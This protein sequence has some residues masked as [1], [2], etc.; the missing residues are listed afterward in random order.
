M[1]HSKHLFTA[2]LNLH[3]STKAPKNCR[4][5]MLIALILFSCV[6]VFATTLSIGTSATQTKTPINFYYTDTYQGCQM[7]YTEDELSDFRKGAQITA[8][9]FYYENTSTSDKVPSV[10]FSVKMG[11]TTSSY[12]S[13]NTNLLSTSSLTEVANRAIGGWDTKS[14]GWVTI[15]LKTPFVYT[16]GNILIDIRNTS[17]GEYLNNVYFASTTCDN[18]KTLSWTSASSATTTSISTGSRTQ[19][20]PNIQFTYTLYSELTGW[21]GISYIHCP[22]AGQFL[23]LYK[24]AGCP[25]VVKVDG[26]I[27]GK[28]FEDLCKCSYSD[29]E[30]YDTYL[31]GIRYLD[32]S[33]ATIEEYT[34]SSNSSFNTEK[35]KLSFDFDQSWITLTWHIQ[36]LVLPD[37]CEYF[38]TEYYY[39]EGD[40]S[41]TKR[42]INNVYSNN[43]TPFAMTYNNEDGILYVPSGTKRAWEQQLA[44]GNNNDDYY[45]NSLNNGI[46][47]DTPIKTLS[48]YFSLTSTEIANVDILYVNCDIDAADFKV[49]NKMPQ[50]NKLYINGNIYAYNGSDGPLSEYTAYAANEIPMCAFKGN[51]S[52]HTVELKNCNKIGDYAFQNATNL[53]RYKAYINSSDHTNIIGDYAFDGCVKLCSVTSSCYEDPDLGFT[54]IGDFAFRNSQLKSIELSS[55]CAYTDVSGDSYDDRINYNYKP[56]THIGK[57]PFLG[58]YSTYGIKSYYY[59][60]T[61]DEFEDNYGP[62]SLHD[63]CDPWSDAKHRGIFLL[64]KDNTLYASAFNSYGSKYNMDN[65]ISHIADYGLS[66]VAISELTISSTLETVG[67]AFLYKCPD[68]KSIKGSSP[69]FVAKDSV[70]YNYDK[71]TLLK[72]PSNH[73]FTEFHLPLSVKNIE[74]WAFEGVKNLTALYVYKNEPI[75]IEIEVFENVDKDA[76]ILYVPYGAKPAYTAAEGWGEFTNIVELEP[77]TDVTV[78]VNEYGSGTYCSQYALD[79]SNVEGLKAYAATGYKTSTGVV[80]LTRVMTSQPGMGLFLKGEPGEYVVPTLESTDENSLNM[81]VGLLESTKLNGMS[82]DAQYY[83]YRYTIHEG[84]EEP[85]FYRIDEGYEHGAGKAYLQIPVAWMPAEAKSISLR[86]DDEDGTTDIEEMDPAN[87]DAKIIYDLMGRKVSNPQEGGVY[88]VNGNKIVW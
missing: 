69:A 20:R 15:E 65:K 51:T 38:Y 2:L 87:Q 58:V 61:S 33:G 23:Q 44:T 53:R 14:S 75:D 9:S 30:S 59:F 62:F 11:T 39:Y 80:T 48:N 55:R 54:S 52:L 32:L 16:G 42:I 27:N 18:Y 57:N 56:F 37:N 76:I 19:A 36:A 10:N 5:F 29:S 13:S 85:M 41:D 49:L 4:A 78:T 82:A 63:D 46:V 88:I 43:K 40:Y 60:E 26:Y 45:G 71:S 84:D 70:L 28:D 3:T 77:V 34:A 22:T 35:N 17:K 68:L 31:E 47:V 24:E 8:I 86:F 64:L 6:N 50:L 79:F 12:F 74:K 25:S 67:E 21:S 83:N 73:P 1:N 7:I 66:D 81:L 72:Y